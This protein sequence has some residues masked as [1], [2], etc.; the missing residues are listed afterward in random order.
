MFTDSI[1]CCPVTK[2]CLT[3]CDPM[4]YSMPG[5]SVL[6]YLLEFAQ[7]LVH[8]VDGAIWPSH[9]LP[10]PF[11]FCFQ[12][13]PVSVSFPISPLFASGGQSIGASALATVLMNI[14]GWFP[15]VLTGL[16]SLLSKGLSRVFSTTIWKHQFFSSQ[17]FLWSSSLICHGKT[18][19][20]T[21]GT[22][23]SKVISLLS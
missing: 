21:I 5:S 1:C 12:S 20:L 23:V 9:F 7:I 22:F 3:F 13:F 16:I 18:I 6:H 10:P 11:S 15:F 19:A 17:P 8:W 4:D 2:L 14:Q